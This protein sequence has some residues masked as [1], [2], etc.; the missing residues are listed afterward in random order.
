MI[1]GRAENS[2][3][4]RINAGSTSTCSG[5]YIGHGVA[6]DPRDC[7]VSSLSIRNPLSL[8]RIQLNWVTNISGRLL[9]IDAVARSAMQQ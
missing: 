1:V 9:A 8:L 5:A 6:E 7:I 3:F 4:I 2:W